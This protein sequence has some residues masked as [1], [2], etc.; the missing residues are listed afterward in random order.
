MRK[1][2]ELM[3]S[4][5]REKNMQTW[6]YEEDIREVG[7]LYTDDVWRADCEQRSNNLKMKMKEVVSA[8][9]KMY[10]GDHYLNMGVQVWDV[11]ETWPIEQQ[12][13]YFRGGALKYIMRL[14]N[15]DE[16]LQEAKKAMHYCE[17]LVEVLEK[18]NG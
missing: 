8:N 13:G 9:K 12:I 14:G 5:A 3:F 17:K 15:K 2:E 6:D 11:V 4:Q 7:R 1:A 18:N 16:Q 10:G